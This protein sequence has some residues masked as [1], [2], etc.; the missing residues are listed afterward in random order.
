MTRSSVRSLFAAL[1][2][3]SLASLLSAAGSITV[4]SWNIQFLGLSR[5]RD[6]AALAHV[7]KDYDIVVV[8]ELIAAPQKPVPNKVPSSPQRAQLFFDEMSKLGFKYVLSESDTGV[9]KKDGVFNNG[10]A[11]E[12]FVTFYKE[13]VVKPVKDIPHGFIGTPLGKHKKFDRVPYAFAFRSL[14]GK[15]DFVLVSVHLNPDKPPRRKVEL[16]GINEWIKSVHVQSTERDI[17]VLGDM[18]LQNK[19][20]VSATLPT[21][22]I[23]LNADCVSTVTNTTPKPYDHVMLDPTHTTELDEAYGFKVIDLVKVMKPYWK[24]PKKYPGG[25]PYK[26]NPF[27][28][29]YSDH[30]PVVFRI[31]VPTHDDD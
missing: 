2:G 7:V 27:R 11:T 1:V 21:G 16:G 25:P 23:S 8:Q 29:A 12:W 3:L 9:N 10:T 18:N 15:A 4:C 30:S 19:A 24:G 14:D 22:Y 26:H 31:N 20:E 6:N 13:G 5:V 17:I 28:A